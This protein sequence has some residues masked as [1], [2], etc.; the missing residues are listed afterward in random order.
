MIHPFSTAACHEINY[1]GARKYFSLGFYAWEEEG[2][3]GQWE[4]T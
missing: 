1:F 3:M 2:A 4:Q